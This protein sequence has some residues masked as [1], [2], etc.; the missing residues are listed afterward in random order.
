VALTN[1]KQHF[2]KNKFGFEGMQVK[3]NVNKT[4]VNPVKVMI[5]N[6]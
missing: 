2:E 4:P 5:Y 6:S 3:L 1:K